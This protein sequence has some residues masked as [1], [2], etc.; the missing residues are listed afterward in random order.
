VAAL[1]ARRRWPV[2]DWLDDYVVTPNEVLVVP[3]LPAR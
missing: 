2:Y 1:S 3:P